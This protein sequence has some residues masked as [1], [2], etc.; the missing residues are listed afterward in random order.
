MSVF[1][2]STSDNYP[3]YH[4]TEQ[5]PREDGPFQVPFPPG[6]R[7]NVCRFNDRPR[8]SVALNHRV[9]FDFD[10][11]TKFG[12]GFEDGH[13]NRIIAGVQSV[14]FGD[15]PEEGVVCDFRS[16]HSVSNDNRE[17]VT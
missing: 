14:D 10:H 7:C 17:R 8:D 16:P 3:K 15:V 9:G 12:F 11:G 6:L 4:Y 13:L 1:I 5:H 2:G